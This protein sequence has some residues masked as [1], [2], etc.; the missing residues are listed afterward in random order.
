MLLL[1]LTT[2]LSLSSLAVAAAVPS[3]TV[4]C[5]APWV[6][7]ATNVLNTALPT[8]SGSRLCSS[9]LK[10]YQ[11]TTSKDTFYPF[12]P[13]S[14][15][16]TGKLGTTTLTTGTITTTTYESL[17]STAPTPTVTTTT[18]LTKTEGKRS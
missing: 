10:K 12:F 3:I 14:I 2:L 9:I 13:L 7:V 4:D 6:K 11:T 18:V 15:A 8:S 17:I 1:R 5:K 16:L